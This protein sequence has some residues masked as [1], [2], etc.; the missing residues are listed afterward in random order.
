MQS[1]RSERSIPDMVKEAVKLEGLILNNPRPVT[2][3]IAEEIY[4]QAFEG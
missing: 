3:K 4:R 2:E 1:I